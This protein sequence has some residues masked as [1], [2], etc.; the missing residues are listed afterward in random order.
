MLELMLGQIANY[1]PVIS[2]NTI[3]KSST[4]V[5]QIWQTIRLHY[6]FQSSGSHFLDFAELR[7]G[8][9]ERSEDLYQRI[10]AFIEDNLLK[11]DGG[12]THYEEAITEDEELTPTLENLIVLTWLRLIHN[13][14]PKL[15]K[16]RYGTELRSRSL[17]SIKPEISQALDSLLEEI[18]TSED[19]RVLR[20]AT[21]QY[22]QNRSFQPHSSSKLNRFRRQS[23]RVNKQCPLC[24]QAGRMDYQHFLSECLFLPESDKKFIT[25]ARQI[26]GI[27]E[28]DFDYSPNPY[29]YE[30]DSEEKN[31]PTTEASALRDTSTPVPIH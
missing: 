6:G 12:I 23:Q 14:L 16:Q 22:H 2:R 9:D 21:P 30:P 3:V 25:K 26:S 27:T 28:S 29:D 18:H 13:D 10:M 17:A 31:E 7:L 20:T 24:K 11:A 19:A 15:V 4:S 5:N 1:C 8:S